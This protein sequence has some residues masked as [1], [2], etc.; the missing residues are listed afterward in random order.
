MIG[1]LIGLLLGGAAAGVLARAIGL[2]ADVPI[3]SAGEDW[4]LAP[5]GLIGSIVGAV[6]VLPIYGA[7]T[8]RR[9]AR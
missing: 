8:G 7:S 5:S 3:R 2:V 6:I 9:A 1:F 4:G